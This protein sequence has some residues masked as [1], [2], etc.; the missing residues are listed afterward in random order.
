V[1]VDVDAHRPSVGGAT[2]SGRV[3]RETWG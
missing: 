2:G 3:A 1:G